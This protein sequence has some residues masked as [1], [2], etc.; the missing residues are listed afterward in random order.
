MT[1]PVTG[2][3]VR[4][5]EQVLPRL[6]NDKIEYLNVCPGKEVT[7]W[8]EGPG[9]ELPV[10]PEITFDQ[11]EWDEISQWADK[12]AVLADF[13]RS[14]IVTPA[15][16]LRGVL[17]GIWKHDKELLRVRLLDYRE[18]TVESLRDLDFK[19]T[20]LNKAE[21]RLNA[22]SQ[23]LFNKQVRDLTDEEREGFQIIIKAVLS[24]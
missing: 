14:H 18:L 16:N 19:P 24:A 17:Y 4:K 13:K 15:V 21:M 22:L 11:A 3:A 2:S 5:L 8:M 9:L 20:S 7:A 10:T 1:T 23:D 12:E 6:N